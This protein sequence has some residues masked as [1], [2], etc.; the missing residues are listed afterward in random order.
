MSEREPR[1]PRPLATENQ[2]MSV[3]REEI[4][5]PGSTAAK[6][7]AVAIESAND[8]ES[9][10]VAEQ[11]AYLRREAEITDEERERR[12]DAADIHNTP[13]DQHKNDR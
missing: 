9:G 12:A 8:P 11:R 10:G 6:E 5:E 4:S 3:N 7:R 2:E 1:E 13:N